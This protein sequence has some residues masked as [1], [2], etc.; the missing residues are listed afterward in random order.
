MVGWPYCPP[1]L[2]SPESPSERP[3]EIKKAGC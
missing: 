2:G 3:G 1:I